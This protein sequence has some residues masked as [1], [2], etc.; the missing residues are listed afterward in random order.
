MAKE[1]SAKTDAMRRQREQQY[2][3]A[4]RRAKEAAK[5]PKPAP[6]VEA[7]KP[8]MTIQRRKKSPQ[9]IAQRYRDDAND[10]A[11]AA[12]ETATEDGAP[13]AVLAFLREWAKPIAEA[14]SRKAAKE[15]VAPHIYGGG[16]PRKKPGPGEG[17]CS[18]C[19]KLRALKSG[20]ITPHQKG[21]GTPCPGSKK[22]PA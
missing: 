15:M 8:T 6:V 9:E 4:Q 14:P 19:G 13:D 12:L 2:E 21:L 18:V 5:A 22:E 16:D 11:A 17:R 3:E 7:P 20:L 1:G 10:D